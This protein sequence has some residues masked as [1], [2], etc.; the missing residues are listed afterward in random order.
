ML[1]IAGVYGACI[2]APVRYCC[3][4]FR[5]RKPIDNA[6]LESFN[7]TFGAECLDAPLVRVVGGDPADPGNLAQ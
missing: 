3:C 6:F 2:Q 4:E 5:T 7:G 1:A